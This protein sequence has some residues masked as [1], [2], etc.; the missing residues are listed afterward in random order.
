MTSLQQTTLQFLS[1]PLTTLCKLIPP[2]THSKLGDIL[3]ITLLIYNY[4]LE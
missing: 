2:T 3:H 4:L 1:Y